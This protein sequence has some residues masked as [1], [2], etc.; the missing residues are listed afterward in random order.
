MDYRLVNGS[1]KRLM[2]VR[3]VLNKHG[4]EYSYYKYN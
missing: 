2:K 3:L 1:V 4:V